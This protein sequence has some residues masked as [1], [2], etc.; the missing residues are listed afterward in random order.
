M[1][2]MQS[3][4]KTMLHLIVCLLVISAT[5]LSFVFHSFA[6]PLTNTMVINIMAI[7]FNVL[8]INFMH[9]HVYVKN[10]DDPSLSCSLFSVSFRSFIHLF[11]HL[12]VYAMFV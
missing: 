11:I 7:K 10:D 12:F 1:Q 5:N 3:L 6:H 9:L 8:H 2:F 4:I